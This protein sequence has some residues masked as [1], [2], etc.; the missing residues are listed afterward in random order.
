MNKKLAC[1]VVALLLSTGAHAAYQIN[2]I[3]ALPSMPLNAPSV[4]PAHHPLALPSIERGPSLNLP[5]AVNL[6]KIAPSL[7]TLPMPV[8]GKPSIGLPSPVSPLPMTPTAVVRAPKIAAIATV[9]FDAPKAQAPRE[10]AAAQRE[11]L[12]RLF[13]RGELDEQPQLGETRHTLPENDLLNEIGV[14]GLQ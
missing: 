6:P 10:D 11:K 2:A 14:A 4:I 5:G 3:S 7:P 12:E 13:D 1:T 9:R 8:I